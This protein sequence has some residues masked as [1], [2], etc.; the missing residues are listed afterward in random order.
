MPDL[1][2][3]LANITSLKQE[4]VTR[5]WEEVKA[6][7][8]LLDSCKGPHDFGMLTSEGGLSRAKYTCKN[9]GGWVGAAY[10]R[11]YEEGFAHGRA[12]RP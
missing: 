8:K 5:I 4:E 1:I 9:C 12:F 2:K 3:A 11:A 10:R 7:K 6:N